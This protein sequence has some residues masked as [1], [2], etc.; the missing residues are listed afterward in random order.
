LGTKPKEF[1]TNKKKTGRRRE[2][3]KQKS[4]LKSEEGEGTFPVT[5]R[6]LYRGG[7]SKKPRAK[8]IKGR[9]KEPMEIN[10]GANSGAGNVGNFTEDWNRVW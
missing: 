10:R 9:G 1:P 7:I 3:K 6:G 5:R 2:K 4:F 8:A